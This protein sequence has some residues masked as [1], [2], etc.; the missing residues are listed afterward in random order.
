M[1]VQGSQYHLINGEADWSRCT[2]SASGE[3]LATLWHDEDE[4]LPS[5]TPT[6]LQFDQD[7]DV[8][9]LRRDAPLFRRAGRMLPLPESDRRG[10]GRDSY[11][12]WFWIG[13][14]CT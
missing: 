8:L 3:I 6:A 14:D 13:P 9:R 1:D 5:A 10:A 2:D 12:N 7:N 11:G 4:G